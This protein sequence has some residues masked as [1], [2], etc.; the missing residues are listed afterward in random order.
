MDK[1]L[2]LL[3]LLLA[4]L[5]STVAYAAVPKNFPTL[6]KS[7][8]FAYLNARMA[9]IVYSSKRYDLIK[10]GK[11]LSIC[12]DGKTAPLKKIIYRYGKP[13]EVELEVVAT[14][15]RKFNVFSIDE[16]PVGN[17]VIFFD[18]GDFTYYVTEA[19]RQGHGIFL[20]VYKHGNKIL[21]LFSGNGDGVDYESGLIG[22][23]FDNP[24]SRVI[25][26]EAP[27]DVVW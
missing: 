16:T 2:R 9:K 27:K 20:F 1:A 23:N 25:K 4:T 14:A 17:N 12:A 13:G 6:C 15:E 22:I 11:I 21:E 3:F 18:R 26:R 8:E 7:G 24:S 5:S 10:N 19:T